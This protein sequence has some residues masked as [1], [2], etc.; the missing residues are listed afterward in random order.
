MPRQPRVYSNTSIYHIMVR[1]INGEKIFSKGFY[2]SKV[3]NIIK[4]IGEELIFYI[5]AFCVMDNH[6]HLL[7]KAEEEELITLMKRLNIKYAMF[8]NKL[9]SRYGHVFQDRYKSEAV[10]DEK[11]YLGALR[12][13]HNNPVKAR[14]SNNVLNYNWSSVNDYINQKSDIINEY[15][16]SEILKLFKNQ[17]DFIKFHDEFDYNVYVDTKEDEND[18]IQIIINKTINDFVNMYGFTNE[19]QIKKEQKEELAE[20]LL[21]RN[22][23]SIKEIAYLCKLSTKDII[24]IKNKIN[25]GN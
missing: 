12:Y 9:E 14:I 21:K 18:N 16:L 17:N 20:I 13:I 6:M 23:C 2:K 8:Y 5:I 10:E 25:M 22:I 7:V 4:E 3:L 1:G 24:I 19:K 15:Y 11:Y